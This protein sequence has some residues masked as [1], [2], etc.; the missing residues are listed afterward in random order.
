[1]PPTPINTAL[2][3]LPNSGKTTLFNRLTGSNQQ[4][5]NW[6]GVTVEKKEGFYN[7]QDMRVR[8][9]DLPGTYT[10]S[11]Y[12]LDEKVTRD[13]I[14][15]DKPDII[16]AVVDASNLEKNL[17]PVIELLELEAN[18][19]INL[20]MIDSAEKSGIHIDYE[21]ISKVF[22]CPLVKT[23]ANK[24]K[25]IQDL[26]YSIFT[27]ENKLRGNFKIDYGHDIEGSV[28][29]LSEV[30]KN[31]PPE[32][33]L[34]FFCIKALE[35][36]EEILS[37]INDVEELGF[38]KKE[39]ESLENHL[40]YDIETAIIERRF[41]FIEGLV[42]ECTEKKINLDERH[43]IS[44][45]IDLV[46]T[47]RYI[48][49]PLFFIVMWMAF[50]L[51]FSLGNP[52]VDKLDAL[53]NWFNT[54]LHIT[55]I[56]IGIPELISSF[57]TAGV[58]S[59]VGSVLKFLPNILLLFLLISFLEDSGYMA[60][61]SFIV[62]RIM[63]IFGLHGKSF[64]PMI[65]GFG[66][67][68]PAILAAR[69][70][71][72]EKDRII[73]ILILPLMSCSARLPIYTLFAGLFF[74]ENQGLVV[75][76][77]YFIGILASV[78]IARIFRSIFFKMET[79]PLIMEL[80]P[81]RLPQLKRTLVH[82]WERGKHFV[83]KAGTIIVAGVVVIWILANLP[84]G[85]EYA[86]KDSLI[87]MI[88]S[89]FSPF[90]E[91]AGFGYWQVAVALIMGIVAKEIVVGSLGTLYGAEAAGL[92]AVLLSQFTPLSA[93]AFMVMALFY[94]P[95][96]G[97]IGAIRK[98]TNWKWTVITISYT[99]IVGWL[100]AVIVYQIGSLFI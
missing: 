61:A 41:G 99:M 32:F 72:S 49:L 73:T 27:Y 55:M 77:L 81:Y 51:V 94:I 15:F 13:Y 71:E 33:N 90:L 47:N 79:I 68:I 46:L 30:F 57:L 7:F 86:S 60:R 43:S 82:M 19:L 95:C 5:G 91:P 50:Q 11:P 8:I 25:G 42:K 76:S 67:N 24:G 14:I 35:G 37:R 40:G 26:K 45:K 31:I 80:P 59:G 38:L 1:M 88:G 74:V 85:V 17:Y 4:I 69:T 84:P 54:N 78:F 36:D 63:H 87:G 56:N 39:I 3:G 96:I 65:I 66:C 100:L 44:D 53:F 34:R 97:A 98:E 92:N 75:F 12:S 70:L 21:K 64:I 28:E 48:G 62:D 52:L 9:I 16:V 58:L 83:K 29:K 18:V 10:L 93:Y 22:N 20:N 2:A 89:L 6:P 23:V